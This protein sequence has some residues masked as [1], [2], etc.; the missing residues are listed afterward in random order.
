MGSSKSKALKPK[1]LINEMPIGYEHIEF[2]VH[3][4]IDFGTDGCALA[5]A[6]DNK[7]TIYNKWRNL[8]KKTR[9][10]K[11]K[12]QLVLNEKNEVSC[13]GNSAKYI[14]CNLSKKERSTKKFFERFKMA[15]Y[16]NKLSQ[17]DAVTANDEMKRYELETDTAQFLTAANGKRVESEIVF[18]AAFKELQGLAKKHLKPIL[19]SR[20]ILDDEIQWILT[21]PAI[22]SESA[23]NKMKQWIIKAGLVNNNIIDQCVIV[24]EPDCASLA[25]QK[26][27]FQPNL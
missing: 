17:P 26:E 23:K 18:V 20:N 7:V 13:F 16:E 5:F 27:Y 6:Y 14:Y 4:A 19:N 21:V 12:T 3:V 8:Q 25:I 22:W 2:K 11:T 1:K 24:Y 10:T 15:L 9:K